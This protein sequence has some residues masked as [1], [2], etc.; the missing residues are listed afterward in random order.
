MIFVDLLIVAAECAGV[1][2]VEGK[3]EPC[4]FVTGRTTPCNALAIVTICV[5]E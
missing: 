4:C 3:E 2:E 1:V 5:K